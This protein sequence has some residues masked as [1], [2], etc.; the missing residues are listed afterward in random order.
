MALNLICAALDRGPEN[1]VEKL[2]LIAICDS[3]DKDSGEAW[4]SLATIARRAGIEPR[5]VRRVLRRLEA[6]GWITSEKQER[7]NG[8]RRSNLYTVN[9]CKLGEGPG[10]RFSRSS[11]PDP[12]S[13]PP[14]PSVLP[15][16]DSRSPYAPDSRSPLE[17]SHNK[18]P[19]AREARGAAS[20]ALPPEKAARPAALAKAGTA[21]KLKGRKPGQAESARA[22]PE[23]AQIHA[24]LSAWEKS[25]IRTGG[26]V[27][28]RGF[29]LV[30]SG[31]SA[32]QALQASLREYEAQ[33]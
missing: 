21:R 15:P 19:Y 6:S 31:S 28:L 29:G 33:L 16:P 3:A 13:S 20:H 10:G 12:R 14:G 11:P 5:S 32:S 26:D 23:V 25:Q 22:L 27:L 7:A 2:V 30:K 8:S 9:L 4:P 17:P 18:E 1:P 24:G